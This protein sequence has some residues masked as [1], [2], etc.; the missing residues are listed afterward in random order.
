M[1]ADK[2]YIAF[3]EKCPANPL[4]HLMIAEGKNIVFYGKIPFTVSVYLTRACN[5]RCLT[6][7]FYA[8]KEKDELKLEEL[9]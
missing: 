4:P 5:L 8:K 6:C 1:R 3:A 9:L 2:D 7:Y